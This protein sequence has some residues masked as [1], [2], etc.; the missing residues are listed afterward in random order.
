MPAPPGGRPLLGAA[1]RVADLRRPELVQQLAWMRFGS[2]AHSAQRLAGTRRPRPRPARW[3]WRGRPGW[4][5]RRC[6]A[7]TSQLDVVG[8]AHGATP[9]CPAPGRR[10]TGRRREA[11]ARSRRR[12]R[13]PHR[14]QGRSRTGARKSPQV[15]PPYSLPFRAGAVFDTNARSLSSGSAVRSP[16]DPLLARRTSCRT[17]RS[18]TCCPPMTE[19]GP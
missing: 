2:A 7:G 3:S 9:A 5:R 12:R 16:H 10:R 15:A 18:D 1:E 11:L 14:A 13:A 4:R 8:V 19:E 6:S 17:P